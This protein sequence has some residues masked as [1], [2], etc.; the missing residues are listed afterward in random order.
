MGVI[1]NLTAK[2]IKAVRRTERIG[3]EYGPSVC[4]RIWLKR[5][6]GLAACQWNKAS[7]QL[8][9][10]ATPTWSMSSVEF[11]KAVRNLLSIVKGDESRDMERRVYLLNQLYRLMS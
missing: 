11:R 10:D 9:V 5:I 2:E 3:R 7:L 1:Y 6:G 8:E 4:N